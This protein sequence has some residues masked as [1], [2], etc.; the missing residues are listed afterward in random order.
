MH[1][2]N[3]DSLFVSHGIILKNCRRYHP[4]CGVAVGKMGGKCGPKL[5]FVCLY[6][7]EFMC[8]HMYKFSNSDK[9]ATSIFPGYGQAMHAEVCS[10]FGN[11]FNTPS[12]MQ[13][14]DFSFIILF[15]FFLL[16][17]LLL[18]LFFILFFFFF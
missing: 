4:T 1:N 9:T 7:R 18:F 14:L 8:V 16:Y 6:V 11:T 13:R 3:S 12:N 2:S 17:F 5:Y 10:S 15:I